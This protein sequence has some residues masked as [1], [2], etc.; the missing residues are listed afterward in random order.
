[1]EPEVQGFDVAAVP[2]PVRVVV[3]VPQMVK[4]PEIVG[5]AFIVM[6]M[7]VRELLVQLVVV[8]RASA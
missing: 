6:L 1:V 3:P 7:L 4:V 8:F 2:E 5:I